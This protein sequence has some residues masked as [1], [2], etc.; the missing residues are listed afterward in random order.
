MPRFTVIEGGPSGQPRSEIADNYVNAI[1]N[2]LPT[3]SIKDIASG[4]SRELGKKVSYETANNWLHYIR[5]HPELDWT[6]P[7]AKRGKIGDDMRFFAVQRN[8]ED[9]PPFD[10]DRQ[11]LFQDGIEGTVSNITTMSR[12]E[13]NAIQLSMPYLNETNGTRRRIASLY[14]KLNYLSEEAGELLE[15]IRSARSA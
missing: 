3:K 4:M 6:V 15:Q 12:T 2:T 1:W 13:A 5:I 7:H 14:R 10:T 9:D 11:R 8:H